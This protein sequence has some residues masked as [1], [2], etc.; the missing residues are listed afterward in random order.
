MARKINSNII[1]LPKVFSWPNLWHSS[2][3]YTKL[4]MSDFIVKSYLKTELKRYGY[5][6]FKFSI[7]RTFTKVFISMF[8]FNVKKRLTKKF[9]NSLFLK[10]DNFLHTMLLVSTSRFVFCLQRLLGCQVH[11]NFRFI[12]R[13]KSTLEYT[14]SLSNLTLLS[15]FFLKNYRYVSA[16]KKLLN[17]LEYAYNKVPLRKHLIRGLR[18]K[19]SGPL[20]APRQ[21]R[22]QVMIRT[23]FG[24][25]P[26]QVYKARISYINKT[27]VLK[28]G[29]VS[30]KFWM[31]KTLKFR[32]LLISK[33]LVRFIKKLY[34]QYK[35]KITKIRKLKKYFN[36]QYRRRNSFLYWF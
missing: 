29:L 9:K 15:N 19:I 25:I 22:S 10:Y 2:K 1:R 32:R 7:K 20:R 34:Q 28:E 33:Y 16:G 31:F 30:V 12:K 27:R 35:E 26:T 11:L 4:V 6:V 24:R 14:L 17:K 5:E 8:T 36:K 3:N 18:I 23:F 13:Q 21:R